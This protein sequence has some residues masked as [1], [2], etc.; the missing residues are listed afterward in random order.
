MYIIMQLQVHVYTLE[1]KR[2]EREERERQ[3]REECTLIHC[4]PAISYNPE[5]LA[6]SLFLRYCCH[7]NEALPGAT[8]GKD[9]R[10]WYQQE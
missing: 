5:S 8:L 3:G 1:G 4:C 7:G 10:V 2:E 6:T 9:P